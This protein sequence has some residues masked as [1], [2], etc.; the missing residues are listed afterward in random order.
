MKT[1]VRVP[2]D[3]NIYRQAQTTA[4]HL[5]ISVDELAEQA[6]QEAL[7]LRTGKKREATKT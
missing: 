4:T 7:K 6:V 2:I 3:P 5:G 1:A